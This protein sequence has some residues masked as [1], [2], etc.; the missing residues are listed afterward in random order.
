MCSREVG[1][2]FRKRWHIG[3]FHC[4][5]ITIRM[6]SPCKDSKKEGGGR[7]EEGRTF[8]QT[9]HSSCHGIV[10]EGSTTVSVDRTA[11]VLQ[12]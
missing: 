6:F 1:G 10:G 12:P 7:G 9:L 4:N 5:V 3:A 11:A 2:S 8:I